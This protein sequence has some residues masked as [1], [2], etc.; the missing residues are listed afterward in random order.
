V[1]VGCSLVLG[2]A[3]GPA[4][5]GL[6]VASLSYRTI[7]ALLAAVG[8]AATALVVAGVPE[9]LA[10]PREVSSQGQVKPLGALTDL[11][12]TP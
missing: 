11:S 4:L 6:V 3:I 2:S 9:T 10:C 12:T 5:T 8:A 1:I 7:F